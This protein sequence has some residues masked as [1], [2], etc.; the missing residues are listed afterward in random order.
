[1]RKPLVLSMS[2][3]LGLAAFIG[4]PVAADNDSSCPTESLAGVTVDDVTVEA[5]GNCNIRDSTIRGNLRLEKG[6]TATLYCGL[7]Q[8]T[9]VEGNVLVEKAG[10]LYSALCGLG[11]NPVVIAGDVHGKKDSLLSLN[12]D[13]QGETLAIKGDIEVNGARFLRLESLNVYGDVRVRKSTYGPLI[14]ANAIGGDLLFEKNGA[15]T[16]V[17]ANIVGGDCQGKK[18]ATPM[19]STA[20]TAGGDIEGQ[21]NCAEGC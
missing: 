7:N 17:H 11:E 1:M 14:A 6:A 4:T 13:V 12:G 19:A 15:D 21:C 3:A 10:T 2:L 16:N 8:P 20:N 5:G 9:R 18:N